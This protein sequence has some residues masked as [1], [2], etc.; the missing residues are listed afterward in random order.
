MQSVVTTR[1]PSASD[2]TVV[3][4]VNMEDVVHIHWSKQSGCHFEDDV[5]NSIF[6]EKCSILLQSSLKYVTKSQINNKA[7]WFR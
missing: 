4:D 1:T 5:Y 7:D 3:S 2:P 6:C